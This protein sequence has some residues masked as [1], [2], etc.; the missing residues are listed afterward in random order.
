M[1]T[2]QKVIKYLAFAFAIFLSISIISGILRVFTVLPGFFGESSSKNEGSVYNE[3]MISSGEISATSNSEITEIKAELSASSLEIKTGDSFQVESNSK[4]VAY[5]TDNHRLVIKEKKSTLPFHWDQVKVTVTIPKGTVF[6]TA[7]IGAGAGEV[8][9][10]E[11][12]ADSLKIELGAGELQAQTLVANNNA[13]INGG[14][15]RVSITN[16]ALHNAVLD[17]GVSELDYR[18]TLTGFSSVDYGIGETQLSLT[19]SENDYQ[20]SL[21]KGIDEATVNGMKLGDSS[22]YGTGAN[23]IEIDGGIGRNKDPS[24]QSEGQ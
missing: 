12:I 23:R 14:A 15:G 13:R 16:G 22:V 8:D 4:D 3:N 17:M 1:T 20:I 21:D 24:Q 10:E 11:L 9:I 7:E 6:Q 5:K 18:G 19:D 2:F